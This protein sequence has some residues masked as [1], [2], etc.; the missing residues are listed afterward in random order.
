M[1]RIDR[2]G[3][4][5]LAGQECVSNA[6]AETLLRYVRNGGTLVL[7]DNTAQYNEWRE[8][9]R[10][11]PLLPARREGKGRIIYIPEIVR[12]DARPTRPSIS[13]Q[14]PEPG[15]TAQRGQR[16]SPAQWV[17][18]KNHREIYQAIVDGLPKG[19]SIT[20]EA[21]L[22]TVMELLN[23]PKT[24][25]TIVHFINF[26]RQNRLAPFPVAVRKQFSGRVKSVTCFS[27]DADDPAPVSFQESGE[28]VTFTAPATR[29]YLMIVIAQE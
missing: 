11:N 17:L 10:A 6:Q 5:I 2:Y 27:P 16:M 20:S 24:H 26:D 15:A 29:L 1:D 22:T 3:A 9:R 25:E 28:Q 8:R 18:P 23:R 7:A 4:V 19:L 14:D 13:D 21:P 12:A